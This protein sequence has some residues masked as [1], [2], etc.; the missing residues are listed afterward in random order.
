VA[1]AEDLKNNGINLPLSE[2]V[3][4]LG[5]TLQVGAYTVPN[6]LAI[7]PMEGCDSD[8]IGAPGEL[9]VRRYHRFA[10]SGAGLIWFEAVAV[11]NE[12]RANPRQLILTEENLDQ[13]KSLIAEIK[14]IS[15][16]KYG[17]EPVIVMQ[18]TH[19]GRYSK[20]EG[21]AAPIVMYSHPIYEKNNPLHPSRIVTDDHLKEIEEAYAKSAKLA[22]EAGFDGVDV[23][24]CHRYLMCESFSAYT[25]PGEYGGCYENRTR[26]FRNAIAGVKAAVSGDV[27]VTSRMNIYDAVEYP[28]GFGVAPGQGLKPCLEE[29]IRLVRQMHDEWG[30][31]MIDITIGNPYFNPHINRPFDQGAYTPDEHP[32]VGVQRAQDC[33]AEV[34]AAVPEMKIISSAVS[35]LRQFSGNLAAGIVEQGKADMVG[36]GRMAFAYPE[37]AA[38]LLSGKGMDPKKICLTCSKCTELMRSGSTPGCI[39]RDAGVYAP[40]Y[41]KNVLENEKDIRHMVSNV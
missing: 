14:E 33:I 13:Y 9:T 21:K 11:L 37:F 19:S 16:K 2:N 6:R 30:I 4:V 23:K 18:A 1:L 8:E 36:F 7:Q 5:Q 40:L 10:E 29:P 17:Y 31:P 3:D 15:M 22:V 34:K 38:D 20:P 32:F 24:A 41:K 12:G 26:L 28:Y 39:I 27:F 35:Y 25:R